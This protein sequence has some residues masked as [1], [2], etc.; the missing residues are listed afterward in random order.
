MLKDGYTYQQ[1]RLTHEKYTGASSRVNIAVGTIMPP[2][3]SFTQ[4]QSVD[5]E[6]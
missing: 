3:L 6:E 4:Y 1:W 5:A 2:S